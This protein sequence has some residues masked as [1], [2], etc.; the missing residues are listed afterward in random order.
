MS[1]IIKV[2]GVIGVSVTMLGCIRVPTAPEPTSE[3]MSYQQPSPS[4]ERNPENGYVDPVV[5]CENIRGSSELPLDCTFSYI[6]N[7]PNMVISAANAEIL[8]EAYPQLE[9]YLA[10]PFCRAENSARQSLNCWSG[11][12]TA[13]E[14]IR[15]DELKVVHIA[16]ACETLS[17]YDIGVTC[18]IADFDGIASMVLSF[19][20][21]R[22]TPQILKQVMDIIAKPFCNTT[23]D[24]RVPSTIVLV[25][26]Q[27]H[28]RVFDCTHSRWGKV[29][30]IKRRRK[31]APRRPQSELSQGGPA[32]H[33]GWEY[34]KE[35]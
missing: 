27:R 30:K 12:L 29:F 22:N 17:Q 6:D 34:L 3:P 16:Q 24:M 26:N 28:G 13:W 8:N 23:N 35:R 15:S 21:Q 32:A 14:D 2:V 31:R 5:L 20:N 19:N 18:D 11:E 25:E 9:E 33:G 1:R 10:I 7:M 4:N